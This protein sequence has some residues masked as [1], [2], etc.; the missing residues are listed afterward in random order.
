MG[1]SGHALRAP[2]GASAV[3]CLPMTA[4]VKRRR[5]REGYAF[6]GR[7]C[8]VFVASQRL[9][10]RAFHRSG[11]QAV[12]AVVGVVPV[13]RAVRV[14]VAGVVGRPGTKKQGVPHRAASLT[15][16]LRV[17]LGGPFFIR[18]VPFCGLVFHS[19][20]HTRPVCK[21]IIAEAAEGLMRELDVAQQFPAVAKR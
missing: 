8:T 7:W 5:L 19:R 3:L 17:H 2:P 10:S 14:D 4:P 21:G 16:R 1:S 13:Q 12:V 18:F 6:L 11:A 9:I 20:R 15:A